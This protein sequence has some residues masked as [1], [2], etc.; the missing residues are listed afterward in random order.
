MISVAILTVSDSSA[1][2]TRPDEAGPTLR[3]ICEEW[4]WSVVATETV[5]DDTSVIAAVIRNWADNGVAQLILTTGGTGVSPRDN[6]PEATRPL[7]D[8]EIDGLGELMRREGERQ[9]PF[10]VLSRSLAGTRAKAL[11]VNLPG[12][13]NG[14]RFSL[15]IIQR[16]VPHIIELLQGQTEHPG[17][18]RSA[19]E[20]QPKAGTSQ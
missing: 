12:S 13:P 1:A 18:K 4:K 14:A 10:S 9:T 19:K 20:T 15:Q 2:G 5:G 17:N 16:F 7:L 3:R 8:R 11:I 6:T